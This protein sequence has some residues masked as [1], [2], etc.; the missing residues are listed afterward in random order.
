MQLLQLL[1]LL[2]TKPTTYVHC[3]N[4]RIGFIDIVRINKGQIERITMDHLPK[5]CFRPGSALSW[6]TGHEEL[7]GNYEKIL[8]MDINMIAAYVTTITC[9]YV[10]TYI[11]SYF[12]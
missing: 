9:T 7:A 10:R 1:Q 4:L 6:Y 2:L 3:S 8:Q 12:W 11:Q 5:S